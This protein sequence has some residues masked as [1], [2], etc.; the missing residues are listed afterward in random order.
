[1]QHAR[2]GIYTL[3]SGTVEEV[4]RKAEQGMLPAFAEQPGFIRYGLVDC[5]NQAVSISIWE[6]EAEAEAANAVAAAWIRD[7]LAQLVR[8]ETTYVGDL[9]FFS[10]AP[11]LV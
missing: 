2:V 8:L 9:P 10:P 7:N 5:G 11:A 6:T 4:T 3:T 1:M